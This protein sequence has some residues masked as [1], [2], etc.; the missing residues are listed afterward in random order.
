MTND[1]DRSATD[2]DCR[3]FLVDDHP[4]IRRGIAA[5]IAGQRGMAVCGEAAGVPDAVAGIARC[6]PRVAVV[7][8]GL[9]EGNGLELIK[10]IRARFPAVNVLVLSMREEGFYAE[11]ALR[12]GALG[13]IHK[14]EDADRIVEGI[15]KLAAG[16]LHV[17]ESVTSKVMGKIVS[18]APGVKDSPMDRL[19]DRELE[20]LEMIG[21]GMTTREIA[22]ALFISPKTVDSHREHIKEKLDIP[23]A[24]ELLRHAVHWIQF[25]AQR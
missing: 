16:H 1:S 7:D 3:I 13:Y 19:T 8:L 14:D 23:D 10:D 22:K 21:N 15:R 12:A 20:V 2:G 18:A 17:S 11:R 5:L 24:A 4:V 6:E 25:T 9:K